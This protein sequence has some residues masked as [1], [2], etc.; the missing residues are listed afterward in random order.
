MSDR[1]NDVLAAAADGISTEQRTTT[2]H[3]HR[4]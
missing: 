4:V 1:M 2:T 3:S